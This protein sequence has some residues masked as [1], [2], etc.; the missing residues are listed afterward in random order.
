MIEWAGVQRTSVSEGM[1]ETSSA[2]DLAPSTPSLQLAMPMLSM[3]LPFIA[4]MS[5]SEAAWSI[6]FQLTSICRHKWRVV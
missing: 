1:T 6:P 2:A 5:L 4:A 3:L